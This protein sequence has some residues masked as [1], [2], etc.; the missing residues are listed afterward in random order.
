MWGESDE[1]EGISAQTEIPDI[2]LVRSL[3][4]IDISVSEDALS[5]FLIESVYVYHSNNQALIAPAPANFDR[6]ASEVTAPSIPGG[7][8]ALPVQE[9]ALPVPGLSFDR[10]IYVFETEANT[11]FLVIGGSYNGGATTYY[12]ADFTDTGDMPVP[13]L[14][15]NKYTVNITR[16][17]HPGEADLSSFRSSPGISRHPG[18]LSK[19]I[20]ITAN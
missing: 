14:R 7:A 8:T 15:N 4:R 1:I 19:T 20:I 2:K 5:N 3:A 18:R 10:G 11:T 12:Q 13:L 16:V 6:I 9:Y 17:E